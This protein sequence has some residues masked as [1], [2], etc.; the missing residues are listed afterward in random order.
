[1]Y[2]I[3][4]YMG[5]LLLLG[6]IVMYALGPQRANVMNY[7]Y[8]TNY[9]DT[10]FFGKQL[11]SVAIAVVAFSVFYFVPY[12]W[13]TG[14]RSKYVLW[15]GFL[16]CV[17]LF[18]LGSLLHLSLAKETNGAYRWFYL[19]GLG[20][21]QPSELLKYGV[22]LFLAGFLGRRA[23]Q[24]KIND[25][26]ET[27]VPVGV[28]SALSLLMIVVL[29]KDLGTGVSLI[30]IVLSMIIVS[31]V[32]WKIIGKILGVV[33]FC[34]L[35]LI[36]TSPHRIERVM[37]FIQGD[38][39]K[40]ASGQEDKN[41]HIQQARIAI[42][43]GGILGLGIGKS[44]QATGYLPEAIND[45]IFAVMGETF[46]FVGLMAILALFTALLL[47]ILHV[48]ARLPDTTLRLIVAGIFGWIASH[49]VLN[50]AAMTGLM[51][52][53]G[54]PLPLLSYGGTSMLFIA[55]ALGLVFQISKYT[56]H[57]VLEEGEGGQDLSGRRRLRRTRYAGGSRI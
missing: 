22:L 29:Q 5:L 21:F 9:S 54:I 33:A 46:G 38:S 48:A 3:V 8:G 15:A 39:H 10:Y 37:T 34:G 20:S 28:I 18:L 50:I 43:S 31:G 53:T 49:V 40:T 7:A 1:M 4:L 42:G 30:A 14:E 44:V 52:L 16:S 19:G 6:L 35:V 47:S 17:L 32:D 11:T 12:K 56:S 36:F 45:S 25:V 27:L 13:F 2:Q 55:A 57:K 23:S 41:Y 51:P 24:G 26:H